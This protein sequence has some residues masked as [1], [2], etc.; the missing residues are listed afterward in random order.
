MISFPTSLR[1]AAAQEDEGKLAAE[2]QLLGPLLGSAAEG[3]AREGDPGRH[4][5]AKI[6]RGFASGAVRE[7]CQERERQIKVGSLSPLIA[8]ACCCHLS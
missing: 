8:P 6:V 3:G 1:I 7:H 2:C 4:T 5:L